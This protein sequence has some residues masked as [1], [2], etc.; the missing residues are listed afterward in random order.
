M[1]DAGID[2]DTPYDAS[3]VEDV[4]SR[5]DLPPGG[6][7][8]SGIAAA[9]RSTTD[10]LVAVLGALQPWTLMM[11]DLLSMMIAAEASETQ[12]QLRAHVDIAAASGRLQ[13]DLHHF[14]EAIEAYETL[15]KRLLRHVW[16]PTD[17][18][19]LFTLLPRAQQSELPADI[20]SW[21]EAYD[22]PTAEGTPD[23]AWPFTARRSSGKRTRAARPR[24]DERL[25]RLGRRAGQDES[26]CPHP[27]RT[28]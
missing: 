7:I 15:Q 28:Q 25:P 1:A 21:L 3:L 12:T 13:L 8:R 11:R 6:D 27:A 9:N 23:V 18:A 19:R 24:A 17:L 20:R 26:S 5:L 14:S 22:P 16:S 4:A 10:V 2:L